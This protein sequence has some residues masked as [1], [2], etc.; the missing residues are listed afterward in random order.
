MIGLLIS[1]VILAVVVAVLL[2]ICRYLGFPEIVVKVI[3]VLAVL[4]ALLM[5][6]DGMGVYHYPWHGVYVR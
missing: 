4:A 2:W 1:L 5:L 6:L 3:V